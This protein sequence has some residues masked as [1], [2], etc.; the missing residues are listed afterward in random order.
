M[1]DEGRIRNH[2]NRAGEADDEVHDYE[3]VDKAD[4]ESIDDSGSEVGWNS[5]NE[6]AFTTPK[7][8]K[9]KGKGKGKG[10]SSSSSKVE[11]EDEYDADYEEEGGILLSDILNKNMSKATTSAAKKNS[12]SSS[13]KEEEGDED[14]LEDEEEEEESDDEDDE[15]DDDEDDEEDEEEEEG[16][17]GES[18]SEDEEELEKV[19]S[20]LLDAIDRF[21]KPA[22]AKE[23][24][25]KAP[26]QTAPESAYSSMLDNGEVSM[27][28]LLGALDDTRGLGVVKKHL[29][30]LERGLAA[31]VHV[32]K[33]L[34]ERIE[35]K[36]TYAGNKEDMNKWQSTVVANRQLETLNL[37]TEKIQKPS[38]KSMVNRFVPTTDMEKEIQ[39][40]LV[41]HGATDEEAE[42][43]EID[44]LQGRNLSMQEIREKQADLAK[45]KALMFYEQMKRHRLNKIKSKAYRKIQKKKKDKKG[46]KEEEE[47]VEGEGGAKEKAAFKRVK[48]RMDMRHKNTSK[49]AKMA[50]QHGH[51]DKSL[52]DAYH[53]SVR[54]GH[55]LAE[56]MNEDLVEERE[57]RSEDD[58]EGEE[59]EEE[60]ME[61]MGME[62][63]AASRRAVS[64]RASK[65]IESLLTENLGIAEAV[66][67][68][69]YRKLFEMDFMKKAADERRERAREEAQ[70]ILREI[71]EM[72]D[73]ESEEEEQEGE[74]KISKEE[75]TRAALNVKAMLGGG[76]SLSIAPSKKRGRMVLGGAVDVAGEVE[77]EAPFEYS[78]LGDEEEVEEAGEN[79]W[80]Q[81]SASRG[82]K[83]SGTG[84]KG[85]AGQ[86]ESDI[87]LIDTAA[88]CRQM[89]KGKGKG[90]SQSKAITASTPTPASASTTT[91]IAA[92]VGAS[93]RRRKGGEEPVTQTQTPG[94]GGSN[95]NNYS[96]SDK[97]AMKLSLS[98]A[99]SQAQLVQTAFAGP[100]LEAEFK[101]F[102]SQE[103]DNELGL[104]EKKLKILS[105]GEC[106][107]DIRYYWSIMTIM[108]YV[109]ALRG[110]LGNRGIVPGS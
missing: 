21:A 93:K 22:D 47:D 33:V 4:D 108:S 90:Q 103:V 105:D 45:V 29:A 3:Y 87:V 72:E 102:K 58:F 66:P 34:A 14:E 18:E 25:E 43:R 57:D 50:L 97:P 44:E 24:T 40:V 92:D 88:A 13:S 98:D 11:S 64:N 48:E 96:D 55:S 52:R 2:A 73:G 110:E 53:D 100:D 38:F 41:K 84:A 10:K 95:G 12:K 49:W 71:E 27:T 65:A 8:T 28:A 77:V 19:H 89:G 30:D 109:I 1:S 54:L 35:R 79:P 82:R 7:Y 59:R 17:S 68:G 23:K 70:K 106:T 61:G 62:S 76:S 60:G 42:R 46:E 20:R 51:N 32:E 56:K 15:E 9:E 26:N 94:P 6:H 80:L 5:D 107:H 31:P 16:G 69:K 75:L 63:A 99:T 39:M 85:E 86:G 101:A 83:S 78:G 91:V 36:Q 67:S 37:T 81:P 74:K 104:D